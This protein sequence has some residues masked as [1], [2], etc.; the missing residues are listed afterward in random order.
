MRWSGATSQKMLHP[1]PLSLQYPLL[2]S[3]LFPVN[4]C[5]FPLDPILLS[6][7]SRRG[8]PSTWRCMGKP[9]QLAHQGKLWPSW[10]V[11]VQTSKMSFL[12]GSSHCAYHK[13]HRHVVRPRYLTHRNNARATASMAMA[14]GIGIQIGGE[15]VPESCTCCNVV[16]LRFFWSGWFTMLLFRKH[17]LRTRP[18]YVFRLTTFKGTPRVKLIGS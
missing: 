6:A 14:F 18:W 15:K 2:S 12:C 16:A 11:L 10:L 5:R 9:R 13:K 7:L 3:E 8:I 1:S 4:T 17:T